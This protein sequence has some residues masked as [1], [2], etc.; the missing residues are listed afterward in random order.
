MVVKFSR[1]VFVSGEDGYHTCRIPVFLQ[2]ADGTLLAFCEGRKFNSGDPGTPDNQIDLLLKRSF[3]GGISWTETL[4]IEESLPFW[5]AGNPA[6]VLDRRTGRIWLHYLRCQPGRGSHTSRPGSQDILNLLRYSDD[7]GASW[8]PPADITSFCRKMDEETWR[9]TVAGPGGAI[10][11]ASGRL[12]VPCWKYEPYAVFVV[13]SEDG[14]KSWERGSFVPNS[15]NGNEG[16]LALLH[17]N[18]ILFDFR[19]EKSECRGVALSADGGRNWTPA[20]CGQKVTAVC[21]GLEAVTLGKR[22]YLFWS[23]PRGPGRS[24]LVVRVSSDEGKNWSQEYPVAEGP[25]AYSSLRYLG[26]NK[27]GILWERGNYQFITFTCLKMD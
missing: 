27:L 23:G 20:S 3:D 12:L 13:F 25:A 7:A 5:S 26:Q 4:I 19:Q 1:D 24:N 16:Q 21:C 10:Q 8:S 18:L 9:C 11:D 15:V 2:A 17:N 6:P 14:G 22:R